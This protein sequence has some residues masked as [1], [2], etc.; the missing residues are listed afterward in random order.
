MVISDLLMLTS[1]DFGR[2]YRGFWIEAAGLPQTQVT[3]GFFIG[4]LTIPFYCVAAWHLSLAIRGAGRWASLMVL[5]AAA[6]SACLLTVWHG[7]FAFTS[8]I[9]R[10]EH[11]APGIAGGPTP[12]AT[13][14]FSTYALPL[15]RVAS[16]V[17]GGALAVVLV[18]I[19]LGRTLYPRWAIVGIP[20]VL[21]LIP[22]VQPYLPVWAG[23][24]LS[25]G[26]WNV[27]GALTFGAS[28]VILWNRESATATGPGPFSHLASRK[29]RGTSS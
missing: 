18:L 20:A 3:W 21:M 6:Y 1:L 25:A 26:Y 7:A 17:A 27:A 2:P 13:L 23:V 22:V 24:I 19:A 10:A 15:F 8:S 28:T 14:V 9:L 12:A 5:V 11:L 16:V 4:E 29:M